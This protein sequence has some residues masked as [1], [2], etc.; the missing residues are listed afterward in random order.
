MTQPT[1]DVEML[2]CSHVGGG[3]RFA[4][5]V[6]GEARGTTTT[7]ATSRGGRQ[8]RADKTHMGGKGVGM[9]DSRVTLCRFITFKSLTQLH[10]ITQPAKAKAP[11]GQT[12][13]IDT[14]LNDLTSII[15][16]LF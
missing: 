14:K 3:W 1:W 10:L 9:R 11:E 4:V 7:F 12:R 8:M 16:I 6:G 15:P 5:G 13:A 2:R